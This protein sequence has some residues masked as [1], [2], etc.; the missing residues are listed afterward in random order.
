MWGQ[1]LDQ[2]WMAKKKMSDKIN[3]PGFDALYDLVKKEYGVLGGKVI[4]AGGGGFLMLYCSQKHKKL[5]QFMYSQ[6]MPRLHYSI[7]SAGTSI[8]SDYTVGI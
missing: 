1:Y 6:G 7:Y 8:L 2:H 4:G 5:E 3:L